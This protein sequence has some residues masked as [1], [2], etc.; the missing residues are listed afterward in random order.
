MKVTLALAMVAALGA[1]AASLCSAGD[2]CCGGGKKASA[3]AIEP[4]LITTEELA[5]L[6]AEKKAFIF[7][8]N[9]PERFAKGHIPG[10]KRVGKDLAA[11][12]LPADKAATLVFYCAGEQCPASAHAAKKA[13]E[14]GYTNVF[15]YK[16][17]IA[18]W[19]AAKQPTEKA[20]AEAAS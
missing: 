20:A 13:I 19:E 14:L 2:A 9:S 5:K 3:E 8:V 11:A 17:G 12:D 16:P 7:D 1:G 18:G 10:A 15:V 6:V 4:K